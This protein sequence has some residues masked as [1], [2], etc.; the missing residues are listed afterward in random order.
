MYIMAYACT[1]C[2]VLCGVCHTCAS[3]VPATIALLYLSWVPLFVATLSTNRVTVCTLAVVSHAVV[4]HQPT[5]IYV[6]M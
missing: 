2:L 3:S 4:G 5:I 6:Q 1:S